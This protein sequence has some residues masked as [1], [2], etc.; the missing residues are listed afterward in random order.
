MNITNQTI[1]RF[2]FLAIIFALFINLENL[3]Y[4][5]E[6]YKNYSSYNAEIINNYS[7]YQFNP[8]NKTN[9]NDFKELCLK[10]KPD[11]F[12]EVY[13]KLFLGSLISLV[14]LLV[15][16]LIASKKRILSLAHKRSIIIVLAA[17]FVIWFYVF[18]LEA[19]YDFIGCSEFLK[20]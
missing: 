4:T 13:N 14:I 18:I 9:E 11:S 2:L 5:K 8:E 17:L 3:I 7:I 16:F 12:L 6:Y 19:D 20:K 15:V 1:K 10:L